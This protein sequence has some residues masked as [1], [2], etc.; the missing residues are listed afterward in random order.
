VQARLLLA[1][2]VLGLVGI[3]CSDDGDGSGDRSGSTRTGRGAY[4]LLRDPA[5]RL[6]EA[7][8]P[9][10]DEP[11]VRLERPPMTWY[12]EYVR[13]PTPSESQMV[14]VSG[15]GADATQ[16]R[17]ELEAVGFAFNSVPVASWH[18]VGGSAPDDPGSPT[19]LILDNGRASVLVLSYELD[20]DELAAFAGHLDP[21][22]EAAWVEAGGVV[23]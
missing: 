11:M 14:R 7:I 21:V 1:L 19:I 9:G 6:Q 8:R 16:A 5:W 2:V 10:A 12:A 3:G 23:R 18:A 20:L 4:V 17:A 15:H 13:S 22:D